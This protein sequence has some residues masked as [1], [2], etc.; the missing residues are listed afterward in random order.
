MT[1]TNEEGEQEKED[2]PYNRQ[3]FWTTT[4]NNQLNFVQPIHT[5]LKTGD[6]AAVFQKHQQFFFLSE[7]QY[8]TDQ[9][10]NYDNYSIFYV[11]AKKRKSGCKN[12]N[13]SNWT[14]KLEK[15]DLEGV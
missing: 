1:F 8:T 14:L 4:S 12:D 15:Q 5:I 7:I 2:L 10:N 11:T 9:D 13:K 3:D 6:Q